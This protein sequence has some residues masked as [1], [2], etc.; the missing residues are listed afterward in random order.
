MP[1]LAQFL[2]IVFKI[3]LLVAC[4]G[5]IYC[6]IDSILFKN[7]DDDMLLKAKIKIK[8]E[9]F[10]KW[11]SIAFHRFEI[12]FEKDI[13]NSDYHLYIYCIIPIRDKNGMKESEEKIIVDIGKFG[14]RKEY[15]KQKKRLKD[16]KKN[17]KVQM[18]IDAEIETEK[19][20]EKLARLYDADELD[21]ELFMNNK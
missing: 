20:R 5:S 12:K 2:F 17:N 1:I 16:L 3:F 10:L 19:Y 9:D 11:Y 21:W 14:Y 13:L 15:L 7:Y 4:V 18:K 8:Y 6:V